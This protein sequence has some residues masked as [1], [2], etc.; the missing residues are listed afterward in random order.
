MLS[1]RISINQG[2]SRKHQFNGQELTSFNNSADE[3]IASYHAEKEGARVTV[4]GAEDG[5][6]TSYDHRRSMTSASAVHSTF[7][8]EQNMADRLGKGIPLYIPGR[9]KWMHAAEGLP[10]YKRPSLVGYLIPDFELNF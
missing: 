8:K 9:H 1:D 6:L 10:F 4:V 5:D 2:T 7:L 3:N